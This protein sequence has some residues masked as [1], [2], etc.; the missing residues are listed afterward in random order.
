MEV[1]RA[2]L[3]EVATSTAD[4]LQ[5]ARLPTLRLG[6]L[7]V[8]LDS[9]VLGKVALNELRS[10]VGGQVS[11]LG[12]AEGAEAVDDSEVHN[13]C[14]AP[15][16]R[17]HSLD[18]HVVHLRGSG[19]V[20]VLV[21]QEGLQEPRVPGEVRQDAKLYLGVV[22][23]QESPLRRSLRHEGSPHLS[24]Q[25]RADGYVLQVGVVAG[26]AAGR[27]PR[28]VVAGVDA[29]RERVDQLRQGVHVS[30][31]QLGEFTILQNAVQHLKRPGVCVLYPALV[32][33]HLEVLQH[34][35][36]GGVAR[37]GALGSGQPHL[38]EQHIREL[39][40]RV[41]REPVPDCVEHLLLQVSEALAQVFGHLPQLIDVQED[42]VALHPHQHRHQGHL[43]T[44]EHLR[45]G[46]LLLQRRLEDVLQALGH[47]GVGGSVVGRLFN[48]HMGHSLLFAPRSNQSV[49]RRHLLVETSEGQV[50]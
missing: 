20:D 28:L 7:K 8:N 25:L 33:H 18:W 35:R 44:R 15:H 6:V 3:R 43:H 24:A 38:V 47:I 14:D 11:L 50:L 41:E 31:L 34:G 49:Y 40:G 45:Q 12:D 27:R 5:I 2:Q 9:R 39:L 36:V 46:L 21:P 4:G 37:L 13:L 1:G 26:H 10:L 42:A 48:R 17:G 19:G 23:G 30:R 22:G 29:P 32:E 16:I